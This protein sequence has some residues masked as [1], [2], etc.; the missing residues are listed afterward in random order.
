MYIALCF[1]GYGKVKEEG[2][3]ADWGAQG[4]PGL[5]FVLR[6]SLHCPGTGA[7]TAQ[8]RHPNPGD[9]NP[10]NPNPRNPALQPR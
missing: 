3:L 10:R 4:C 6:Q 8:Q 2:L 9:P 5:H 7:P 1:S